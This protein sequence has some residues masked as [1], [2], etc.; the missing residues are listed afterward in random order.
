MKRKLAYQI[1]T[2]NNKKLNQ[3]NKE[4]II[5][6]RNNKRDYLKLEINNWK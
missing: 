3:I 2:L 4:L 6:N 5:K 1:K